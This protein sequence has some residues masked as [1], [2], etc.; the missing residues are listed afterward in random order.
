MCGEAMRG[1][2]R[3]KGSAGPISESTASLELSG[4]SFGACQMATPIWGF[5]GFSIITSEARHAQ[6]VWDP[7]LVETVW[8]QFGGTPDGHTNIGIRKCFDHKLRQRVMANHGVTL[9]I[10]IN[11][12]GCLGCI[13]GTPNGHPNM[14]I[15]RIFD[16]KFR[17]HGMHSKFGTHRLLE[18]F[19]RSLGAHPMATPI[20][21]FA[22]FSTIK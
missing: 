17:K 10:N 19:G 4:C 11:L 16:H 20:W 21:G 2:S 1:P 18:P 15:C 6:Q 7:Q 9:G 8:V 12:G 13:W 3:N 14:G 22:C 5:A